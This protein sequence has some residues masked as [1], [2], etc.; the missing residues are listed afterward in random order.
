MT[1]E[2]LSRK[3]EQLEKDLERE[4]AIHENWDISSSSEIFERMEQRMKIRQ[5]DVGRQLLEQIRD[6][7][8]LVA[9]YRAGEIVENHS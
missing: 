1:M 5:T 7:K 6:L 3:V 2:E 9:A 4:R 8:D